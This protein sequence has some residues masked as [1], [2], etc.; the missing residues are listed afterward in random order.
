MDRLSSGLAS[1][2]MGLPVMPAVELVLPT[3]GT[4]EQVKVLLERRNGQIEPNREEINRC[5]RR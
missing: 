4:W 5:R 1:G 2:V 3:S